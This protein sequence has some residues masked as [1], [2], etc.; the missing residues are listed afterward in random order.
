MTGAKW[1]CAAALVA[2]L[3]WAA[4]GMGAADKATDAKINVVVVTGG[5]GFEEKP[6]LAVF[7]TMDGITFTHAPQ[8]DDSELFEDTSQWKYN[9]IVLYNM[10]QK[11]SEKRRKNFMALLQKGVG[12][13]TMHHALACWQ[14]WPDFANKIVGGKFYLK[15]TEENGVVRKTSGYKHGVD[16]TVH[17][18]DPNHPITKGLKDF[19]IHDETY[20]R[21]SVSP[22]V[23]VITTTDEPTCEKAIGWTLGC[24][25]ARTC[26]LINGHDA[27]AYENPNYLKLVSNAIR[28]AAKKEKTP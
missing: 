3:G 5:H 28:W 9:V 17:I 24:G 23:H 7:E 8:K 21:Y 2:A 19:A 11:I 16:F 6:F 25:P 27:K 22:K 14:D 26:Y 12:V 20:C 10:G 15:D 18:E 13:V 1:I 4:V